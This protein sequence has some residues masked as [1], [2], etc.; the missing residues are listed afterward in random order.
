[1][2]PSLI[3]LVVP[4]A[5]MAQAEALP[6]LTVDAPVHDFGA[7]VQGAT[8]THRFR[9]TNA[10]GGTLHI[11]RAQAT[12][13]CT[14]TV[15]G[16]SELGPGESTELEVS[17]NSQGIM[18][19]VRKSVQVFS[20][21]PQEPVLGLAIQAEI[22]VDVVPPSRIVEI[23]D[24]AA[25]DDRKL[26]VKF[27]SGTGQPI[28]VTDADLS[29]APWL[30]VATRQE[31]KALWVDLEL[32][33]RRLPRD[34]W[35]GTDTIGLHVRNPRPS[36]VN[37]EV[38]WGRRLPVVATPERVAW[39]G[40]AGQLR[41]ATVTLAHRQRRPFRILSARASNPWIQ[42]AGLPSAASPRQTL[43]LRLAAEARPGT[44][45]EKVTLTLDGPHAPEVEIRV[46]IA[47]D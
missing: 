11:N 44:Y 14:S 33:A 6:R 21:D 39:S 26:S 18:G 34:R 42:V 12:C 10:G 35:R 8:A 45:D 47:I 16:R 22:M 46:V 36:M 38:R 23:Q 28:V 13:G 19:K 15:V 1:M 31:G 40:P 29:E 7:L 20:D 32:L 24:L 41:T 27:D 43:Q 9:L 17:F 3:T 5:C 25:G 37:L 4:I 30:G 2:R